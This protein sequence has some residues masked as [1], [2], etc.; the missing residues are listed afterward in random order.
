M[1]KQNKRVD[2][3]GQ[4]RTA[5]EKNRQI[6]LMTQDICGICGQ[7]VD[8]NYKPPHPLSP[9]VDHIIPIA[10]GGHPSDISNLQL[11]HRWCNRWKSDKMPTDE[12]KLGRNIAEVNNKDLPLH[13]DWAAYKPGRGQAE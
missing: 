9:T 11:A 3:K 1:S 12:Y 6:I 2:H 10:K 5:Y 4:H 13:Y 8:K 7:P